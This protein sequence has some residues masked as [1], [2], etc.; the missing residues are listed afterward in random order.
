GE[1]DA[2]ARA[3]AAALNDY[4]RLGVDV[5]RADALLGLGFAVQRR[6]PERA[7]ERFRAAAEIYAAAGL[8]DWAARARRAWAKL[9]QTAR[10]SA[11]LDDL[12]G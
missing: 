8:G 10:L 9:P 5:G 4:D 12:G 7:A 1:D 2:A 3:H 6:D 11:P